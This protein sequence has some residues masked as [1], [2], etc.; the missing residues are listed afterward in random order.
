MAIAC[1]EQA[2]QEAGQVRMSGAK[3]EVNGVWKRSACRQQD[4]DADLQED[5]DF[6]DDEAAGGALLHTVLVR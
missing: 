3:L 4:C 6:N 2:G 5:P 1:Q